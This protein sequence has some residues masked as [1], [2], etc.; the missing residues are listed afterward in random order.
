MKKRFWSLVALLTLLATACQGS[1]NEVSSVDSAAPASLHLVWAKVLEK[2]HHK[3]GLDY[4][5]LASDRSDLNSYLTDLWSQ[6]LESW[7]E[8]QKL[9]FWINAY[10]AVAASLVVER[11]PTISSIKDIEGIFDEIT[12]PIAGEELSLDEIE[13]RSREFGDPRV[14]FAVVCASESCPDLQ[15][16]P[17]EAATLSEQFE[18]AV[19]GFLED[20]TKGMRFDESTNTLWLSSIFKWYAGD[21]TGGST[22]VAFFARGGIIDWVVQHLPDEVGS[23]LK[24][25]EPKV[26]YL[27][28]DWSLNDRTGSS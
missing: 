10:N 28:Y 16:R 23:M 26:R 24:A 19:E 12:S 18:T 14:H 13:A 4:A 9:A 1:E 15:A 21:F 25:K 22:V 2:Y 7:S 20:R 11:Y 6:S 17:F 3:G 27:D 5:G 8:D